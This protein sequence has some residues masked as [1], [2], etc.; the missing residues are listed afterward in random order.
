VFVRGFGNRVSRAPHNSSVIALTFRVETPCTTPL[1]ERQNERFG[2]FS[3]GA[4]GVIKT[5]LCRYP[6]Q[7]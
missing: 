4:R 7:R 3:S 2:L 6:F 5:A 1:H